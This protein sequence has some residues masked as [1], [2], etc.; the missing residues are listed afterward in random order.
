MARAIWTGSI[1]FGLVNVPIGLY[2]ANESKDVHFNQFEEKSGK[3]VHNKR[4]PEG[5]D[6]EV[7]YE[8]I[9]KGYELSS[10]KY[11]LITPEELQSVEP[12]ASREIAIEDFVD[13]AEIDPVQYKK[14]YYLVP[15]KGRGAD[16]AYVLLREA[17]QAS[18]KVAIGRFVM[19]GKQYLCCIRPTDKTLV[20]QTMYFPDEVR[21]PADL[22]GVPGK[23]KVGDREMKAA[24]QLI[25]SLSSTWDPKRYHDTYRERVL[26]LIDAKKKGKELT[27]EPAPERESV[28]DL[29]AALEAS[30]TDLRERRNKKAAPKKQELGA[31]PKAELLELAK[32]ADIA[33]RT[34]MSKDELVDALQKA[35]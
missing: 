7:K 12:G 5:S 4:V 18:K 26:E 34:K 20:L 30:V 10:G 23:V 29:M 28:S 19:R 21:D 3:R 32:K 11:V 15:E 22:D 16:K 17:M 27:I 14:T 31:L 8:D 1:S 2:S 24:K 13:L 33:G 35:A 6:R 9:V 25:Q